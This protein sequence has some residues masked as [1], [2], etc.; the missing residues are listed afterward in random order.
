ML[1]RA[2]SLLLQ[3][4]GMPQQTKIELYTELNKY[5]IDLSLQQ[6]KTESRIIALEYEV[7]KLSQQNINKSIYKQ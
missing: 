5:I 2:L 4:S 1:T 3:F 7:K 6:I